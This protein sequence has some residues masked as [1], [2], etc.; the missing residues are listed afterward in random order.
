M[1]QHSL[2]KVYILGILMVI[3]NVTLFM[4]KRIADITTS[5]PVLQGFGDWY[6]YI[7]SINTIIFI[8][9]PAWY[10]VT[11]KKLEDG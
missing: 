8:V 7:F 2:A 4:I 11:N 3:I 1:K 10:I 6:T 5:N 9:Y